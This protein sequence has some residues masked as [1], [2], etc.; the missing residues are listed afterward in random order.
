MSN[1][2]QSALRGSPGDQPG[3]PRS[4]FGG[5]DKSAV[6]AT[7]ERLDFRTIEESPEF[8]A[9]RRRLKWFVFPATA[10]FLI[11]Y[12]G[13]VAVAAYAR[14]FMA[15][16]LIGEI[17]VGLVLGVAQFVTTVGLTMLYLRFARRHIDPKVDELRQDAGDLQR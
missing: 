17:N 3:N 4:A 1:A 13:Y 9:L 8:R 16:P 7:P 15:R 10:F 14:E 12:I 6:R 5:I 11:W 2:T